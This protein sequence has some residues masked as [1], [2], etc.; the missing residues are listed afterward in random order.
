MNIYCSICP[1]DCVIID[2]FAAFKIFVP[3]VCDRMTLEG[4][5]EEEG[6]SAC[7]AIADHDPRCQ[8]ERFKGKYTQVEKED[9]HLDEADS[10]D[11]QKLANVN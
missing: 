4:C 1:G 5:H 3:D 8:M 6:K 2:T 11:I 7:N 9:R 10:D